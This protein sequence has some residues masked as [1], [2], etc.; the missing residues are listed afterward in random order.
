MAWRQK[1]DFGD[2]SVDKLWDISFTV[3][4]DAGTTVTTNIVITDAVSGGAPGKAL[5]LY[6]YLSSDSAGQV[7]E[8]GTDC[9]CT[10]GTNGAVIV[11]GGDSS[12]DGMLIAE[13]TGLMDFVVTD[14]G[15]DAY[16]LNVVMPDG[17]VETSSVL[18]FAA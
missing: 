6:F 4:A 18:T 11:S 16:Y 7:P 3:G 15:T 10:A 2:V 17:R 8:A 9:A 14:T 5:A 1:A 13:T 12:I